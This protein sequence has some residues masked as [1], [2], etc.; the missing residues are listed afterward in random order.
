MRYTFD[1]LHTVYD[2]VDK[3]QYVRQSYHEF[4]YFKASR[5]AQFMINAVKGLAEVYE[6]SYIEKTID[7]KKHV[8]MCLS[9]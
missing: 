5:L 3:K 9:V 7:V 8:L 1:D 2:A 4:Y 6:Y